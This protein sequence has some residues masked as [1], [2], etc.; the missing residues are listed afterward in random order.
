M[1]YVYV[2]F[3]ND[4]SV[5][6][7][8]TA[9]LE[10]RIYAHTEDKIFDSYRVIFTSIVKNEAWKFELACIYLLKLYPSFNYNTQKVT[11]LHDRM[12]SKP[13]KKI[14]NNKTNN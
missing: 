13:R 2:L 7:G 1:N 10:K 14:K 5:Y 3:Q 9:Q 8:C 4:I 12:P 6:V 11:F